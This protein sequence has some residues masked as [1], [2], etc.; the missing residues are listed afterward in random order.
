V[1][2][3]SAKKKAE[4][5]PEAARA[6]R[7][8]LTRGGIVLSGTDEVLPLYAGSMHYWRHAPDE[9][10]PALDAMKAMGLLLVDTYVPWGEHEVRPGELDFGERRARLD[11]AHFLRLVHERGLK[12]IVRPG[13]HINAELTYFGL[14]ERI[15]WDRECQ[16]RTPRDNPVVLPLVPVAFPVPSYAS[17]KFHD[18]TQEW[19]DAV[20]RVLSPLRHPDGPIVLVQVD[21]EGALYFRDGAYDQD[22]HP[23]AIRLFREFLREKYGGLKSLRAAWNDPAVTFATGEPPVRFDAEDAAGLA[24]HLDWVESHESLLARAMERFAAGLAQAGLGELPT[25]H[26]FPLGEAATALNPARITKVLDFVGLDYY[27]P[28]NPVHHAIIQRRTSELACRCEG[29]GVPAYGA[30]VGAGFPPFFAPLDEKD[31]LFTLAAGLAYGLRGFN[32]YMA[33]DR[34]RWVGAPIDVHGHPRRFADDYRALFEALT[35]LRFHE[36]RRA[37][38]VRLVVPRVLRR[39]ARASHAFGPVTPALFNILGAGFQ[40]SCLE[41][42]LGLGEVP[43]IAAEAYLRTFERALSVRGV[44][45]AWVGGDSFE[46]ATAG[47]RWVVCAT[48]GGVKPE[49]FE[50]MAERQRAGA[51]VTIGPVVPTKDGR[52]RDLEQPFDAS[53]LEVE[54][55]DDAAR[56]DALVARRIEELGLPTY[57]VDPEDVFV[58]VHE[59]DA[60]VPK[61]AFVLNPN[62]TDR[63]AKVALGK[64]RTLVDAVVHGRHA[65]Q[66]L[67][68]EAGAFSVAIPARTVRIFAVDPPPASDRSLPSGRR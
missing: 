19:F 8:R 31:S 64:A 60:G 50:Q 51:V 2:P 26:N 9:W 59:D 54:A 62:D 24:R 37:A 7:V 32:L 49:L 33:V 67:H 34:D 39:R 21:N 3:R 55:L 10:G 28:A 52:M 25:F 35:K 15:V 13:P 36:L 12:A 66:T 43:T 6:P 4:S 42:D 61:V 44:P 41:E 17:D 53:G 11:V 68:P 5:A 46:S 1:K 20:G 58:S 65:G 45:F 29:R 63:V 38:P 56:A 48:A 16:A 40:E 18:Q 30:E 23:D 57:P 22:Y 14:P 47:A 27:H